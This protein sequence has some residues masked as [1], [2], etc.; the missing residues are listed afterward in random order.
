MR[1]L[2]R[3]SMA[4]L[5]VI[6]C[7]SLSACSTITT[8]EEQ[9]PEPV[10]QIVPS[11][12]AIVHT[13]SLAGRFEKTEQ[14]L[15]IAS[16]SHIAHSL[17][18]QGYDVLLLD[19]GGSLGGTDLVDLSDGEAA[20]GF[21]NAAGYDAITLGS[22][23]LSLGNDLLTKRASQADCAFLSATVT[24]TLDSSPAGKTSTSVKLSDGRTV[25]IFGITGPQVRNSLSAHAA[26]EYSISDA[27]MAVQV[28]NQQAQELRDAGCM[29]VIC[30]AN[31]PAGEG[32]LT[33]H[34]LAEQTSG[35][36]IVLSTTE[37]PSTHETLET[38]SDAAEGSNSPVLVVETASG[39]AE[40]SVVVW[41]HDSIAARSY[42]AAY[43][44]VDEQV[45]AL[46][47]Q[48]AQ[49]QR[50]WLTEAC[51]K[52][53]KEL[54]SADIRKKETGLG[55]LIADASLWES[56]HVG[57]K[58]TP[59]AALIDA[60]S[61]RASLPSGSIT[62]EKVLGVCP[63]VDTRLYQ[64]QLSGQELFDVLSRALSVTSDGSDD[65][66]Q[67]AGMSVTVTKKSGESAPKV[68]IA[69]VGGRKFSLT[70][71]Y[72]LIVTEHIA[73][74]TGAYAPLLD[75]DATQLE[76]SAGKGLIN[77]LARECKGKVPTSYERPDA[78]IT[79]KEEKA[80]S[81]SASAK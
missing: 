12:I 29:M 77:Y 31:L 38:D 37:G 35:I 36:D 51:A 72:T 63:H 13:G 56:R 40:A 58:V 68:E 2:R 46:V 43:H 19:S 55:N 52:A 30:L 53:D 9:S 16:A 71:T 33:A 14:S 21:L 6:A 81:S 22:S 75:N 32:A 27:D 66:P 78:R 20:I 26:Q 23:E 74:G 80:E 57:T 73:N 67:V 10:G 5:L 7:Y 41:E 59:D 39:L 1:A 54:S 25:G 4:I 47:T 62:R 24:K 70:D 8:G 11:R 42:T 60:A 17:E 69:T 64:L 49:E 61:V 65:F 18:E 15:G 76:S 45:N 50:R 79:I 3:V 48:S 44:D 34:A 28:A